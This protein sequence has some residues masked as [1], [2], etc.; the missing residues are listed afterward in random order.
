MSERQ[1]SVR[2]SFIE[3][4]LDSIYDLLAEKTEDTRSN[5][6]QP[7]KVELKDTPKEGV[8]VKDLTEV[9]VRSYEELVNSVK[10]AV[11]QRRT[12]ATTINQK[13]SRSHAVIQ[14]TLLQ[15]WKVTDGAG[16]VQMKTRKGM[17]KIVDLAGSERV[18]KTESE[19]T[20]LEEAKRIN[21]EITTLGKCITALV[22]A[23]KSS[24]SSKVLVD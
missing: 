14:I 24:S 11:R 12:E 5:E 9:A 21:K 19:G 13:S 22:S 2:I 18:S 3:F 17:L 1:F 15:R 20:R 10:K 16:I 4:Y 6:S 7:R 23:E 8:V